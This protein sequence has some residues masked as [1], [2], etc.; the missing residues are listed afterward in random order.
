MNFINFIN[1][2]MLNLMPKTSDK[3]VVSNENRLLLLNIYV[4]Y[5]ALYYS[6][7]LLA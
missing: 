2:H 4:Q 7:E 6:M 3:T 5:C 1:I